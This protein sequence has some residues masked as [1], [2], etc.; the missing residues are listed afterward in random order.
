MLK[1]HLLMKCKFHVPIIIKVPNSIGDIF[2]LQLPV[3]VFPQVL[4]YLLTIQIPKTLPVNALER[5]IRLKIVESRQS[6]SLL[7]H[8]HFCRP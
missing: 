6:L 4:A 1:W 8:C 3:A 5:G 7:F 2:L